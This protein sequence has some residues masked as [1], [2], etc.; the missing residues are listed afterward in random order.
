M[1]PSSPAVGKAGVMA[2]A[3]AAALAAAAATFA[4]AAGAAGAAGRPGAPTRM[5]RR[6]RGF[7]RAMVMGLSLSVTESV[8]PSSPN[9]PPAACRQ[10]GRVHVCAGRQQVAGRSKGSEAGEGAVA[11]EEVGWGRPRPSAQLTG[12]ALRAIASGTRPGTVQ[13]GTGCMLARWARVHLLCPCPPPP[14]T[15][16]H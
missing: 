11:A 1:P 15:H 7:M 3:Q 4:V 9:A 16:I 14:N 5:A 2:G 10:Q 6:L 12:A 8:T 13:A